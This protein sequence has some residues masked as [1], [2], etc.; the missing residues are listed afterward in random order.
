[1]EHHDGRLPA[2]FDE[3][4]KIPGIGDYTARAVLSLAFSMPYPVL[5]A[6]VRRIGQ[7][8]IGRREWSPQEDKLLLHSLTALI[9]RDAP[10]EFN[11]ALMQLGQLVCRVKSP[12]CDACPLKS[13]CRARLEGLQDEIPTPRKRTIK[14]KSSTLFILI[15]GGRV[16][17]TRRSAGIGRGLWFLPA[18]PEGEEGRILEQLG[19][20]IL[21]E[22]K[23]PGQVHL[24]TTWKETLRPL[25]LDLS[26]DPEF[27]VSQLAVH[28]D[29][30]TRW[31]PLDQIETYPSPSV[32]RIIMN[33]ISRDDR[34]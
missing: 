9:P 3:L 33:G 5:D 11:C 29:D 32:Y 13:D 12:G 26:G 18:V 27:P 4:I 6:N 2:T 15:S 16:L 21:K 34:C 25:R 19:S 24:Y 1:M 22:K 17:L 14:E 10:G 31:I 28:P 23:L 7:R 8:L 30:D 20:L